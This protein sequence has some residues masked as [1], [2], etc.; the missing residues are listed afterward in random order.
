[1]IEKEDFMYWILAAALVVGLYCVGA[2]DLAVVLVCVIAG[3]WGVPRLVRLAGLLFFG[4]VG[5]R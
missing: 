1:M 3:A 4:G 5:R 2:T